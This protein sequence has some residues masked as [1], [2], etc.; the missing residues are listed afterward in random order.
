MIGTGMA[1]YGGECIEINVHT[2]Y[3]TYKQ[4]PTPKQEEMGRLC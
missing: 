4:Y 1:V 2:V 3:G